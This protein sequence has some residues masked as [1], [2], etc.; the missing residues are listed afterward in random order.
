MLDD[1]S[2]GRLDA[3]ADFG[4]L[5]LLLCLA[6]CSHSW[7]LCSWLGALII[8]TNVLWLRNIQIL[9]IIIVA[10]CSNVSSPS[11]YTPSTSS[12]GILMALSG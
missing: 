8:T 3:L 9:E 1:R 4:L 10:A 12:T 5:A 7:I 2:N 11:W 6:I